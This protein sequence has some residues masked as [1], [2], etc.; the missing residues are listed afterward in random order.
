MIYLSSIQ[1]PQLTHTTAHTH[2]AHHTSSSSYQ[3]FEVTCERARI[4]FPVD[5]ILAGHTELSEPALTAAYGP[6]FVTR[7]K[8]VQAL[9]LRSP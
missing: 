1:G 4:P 5:A 2:A 7:R 9:R 8:A 3:E 6:D